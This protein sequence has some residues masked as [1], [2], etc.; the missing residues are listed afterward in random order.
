M[1]YPDAVT[2]D[3]AVDADQLLS[4]IDAGRGCSIK[5]SFATLDLAAHGFRQL[6]EAEWVVVDRASAAE[7]W[8]TLETPA[9]LEE[10]SSAWSGGTSSDFFRPTLLLTPGIAVLARY[11][12]GR[13]TA[14]AV[15]NRSRTVIGVSNVFDIEDDF[16][17]AWRGAAGAATARW[18]S[19]P[20]V[21]WASGTEL[22][23]AR[24]AGSRTA[25]PLVV[26]TN[27][28]PV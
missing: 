1:L 20:V 17:A 23:A 16:A 21:G 25:G 26:W 6:I 14:G 9:Q 8:A 13:L 18:E 11:D 12:G 22:E 5:D 24:Q 7:H 28:R 19:M 4:R 3:P 27:A 15:A 2:L 10:W